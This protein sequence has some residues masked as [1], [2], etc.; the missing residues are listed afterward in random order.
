MLHKITEQK[1]EDCI[2]KRMYLPHDVGLPP[3]GSIFTQQEIEIA[4]R[5]SSFDREY[6]L[7]FA[8]ITGTVFLQQKIDAAIKLGDHTDYFKQLL[9]NPRLMLETQ[10]YCA[11]DP[12]FGSSRFAICLVAIV[13]DYVYVI[14]TE[15]LEREEFNVCIERNIGVMEKYNISR[16]NIIYFVDSSSP[17]VCT[18]IMAE[19]GDKTNYT[20]VTSFRTK[21]HVRD[22]W[23]DYRTRPI[24]FNHQTKRNL[25][26]NAKQLLDNNMIVLNR[27]KHSNL[28]LAL[29][30]AVADD[31]ILDKKLSQHHDILD[32]FCMALS[33]ISVA[34]E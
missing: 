23:Y 5:S 14:D 13:D 8:G 32:S 3:Y 18:A 33:R 15:E 19:L 6:D 7:K 1:E 2:Y 21:Q 16:E 26:L 11:I 4:K 30:T 28:I 10:F 9:S 12:S 25:L 22:V 34:K 20:Q 27:V 31:L 29:R 17:A 24:N